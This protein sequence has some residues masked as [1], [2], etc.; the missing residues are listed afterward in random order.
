MRYVAMVFRLLSTSTKASVNFAYSWI[1]S[2]NA[3]YEAEVVEVSFT[4]M[5]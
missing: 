3:R 1:V 5:Q 4:K 2:T